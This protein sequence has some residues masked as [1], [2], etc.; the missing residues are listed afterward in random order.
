MEA[1]S[2]N[3]SFVGRACLYGAGGIRIVS[4][5]YDLG[6]GSPVGLETEMEN[7]VVQM[8]S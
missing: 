5:A 8:Y 1:R 6:G 7:R 3:K 4:H 2:V